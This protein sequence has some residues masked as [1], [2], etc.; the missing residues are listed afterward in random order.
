MGAL[1]EADR[2]TV[3]RLAKGSMTLPIATAICSLVLAA[4]RLGNASRGGG[5][6]QALF[7]IVLVVLAFA[8]IAGAIVRARRPPALLGLLE[9]DAILKVRVEKLRM[10]ESSNVIIEPREGAPI[11]MYVA[12]ANDTATLTELIRRNA[13]HAVV[14][15]QA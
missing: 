10:T 6:L 8:I 14:D 15:A 12:H 4:T 5:V 13:P 11:T 1:S 2:A 7:G 3:T 9:Q